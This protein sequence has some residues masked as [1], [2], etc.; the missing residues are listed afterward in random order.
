M[1]NDNQDNNENHK[2]I[3]KKNGPHRW[4]PGESGNLAG[5]PKK[6]ETYTDLL[7]QCGET[8]FIADNGEKLTAKEALIRKMWKLSIEGNEKLMRYMLDRFDGTP[9]QSIDIKSDNTN[10]N[11][12]LD[13]TPEEQAE[14][15]ARII[16]MFGEI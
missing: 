2:E 7:R 9:R 13:L 11:T 10:V 4:Q 3:I 14:Y 6:G 15:K 1:E 16:K 5:R 8:I 12:E